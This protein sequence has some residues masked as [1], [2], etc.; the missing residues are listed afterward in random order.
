MLVLGGYK[1]YDYSN[2]YRSV[3]SKD[4]LKFTQL[5]VASFFVGEGE[6]LAILK[7]GESIRF[8]SVIYN[9]P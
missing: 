3:C 9:R 6:G 4:H 2:I 8:F 7:L 1:R 5:L